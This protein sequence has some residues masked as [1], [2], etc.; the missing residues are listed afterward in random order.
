M[1]ATSTAFNTLSVGSRIDAIEKGINWCE[2]H[3]CGLTVGFGGSPDETGETVLDAMIMDGKTFSVGSV[4]S[5]RNIKNPISVARYVMEYTK[6]TMLVGDLATQFAVGMGF[7]QINLSTE[8][9][10]KTWEA[11]K[12]DGCT[13]NFRQNVLP[14]SGCG[15]YTPINP[16]H[17]DSSRSKTNF[18]QENNHDTIAMI[19]MDKNGDFAVGTSTNGAMFKVPGRVGDTPIVGSGGYADSDVGGCGATGDGDTMMKFLPCVVAI[20][21]MRNGMDPTLAAQT[22]LLRI[23]QR[24]P[25]F[26]GGAVI[27]VNKTGFPGAASYGHPDWVFSYSIQTSDE[28]PRKVSVPNMKLI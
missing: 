4:G 14:K 19:V 17:L 28:G 26:Q 3:Q 21:L 25:S 24:Y 13:P 12:A 8:S 7:K 23:V 10:I 16:P 2:N 9:S 5:L 20:E 11:W 15:P 27:T 1:E 18:P 6:H 22:A